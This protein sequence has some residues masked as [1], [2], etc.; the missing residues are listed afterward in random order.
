MLAVKFVLR[1]SKDLGE[2]GS[3]VRCSKDY[4]EGDLW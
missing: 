1:C 3:V 4:G 2:G